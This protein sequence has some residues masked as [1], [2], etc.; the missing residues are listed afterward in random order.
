M[1]DRVKK[2]VNKVKSADKPFPPFKPA[3]YFG[4]NLLLAGLSYVML[5]A[6]KRFFVL[7]V[8]LIV[9]SFI[10]GLNFLI[11]VAS[12]FDAYFL[13]KKMKKG[14]VAVPDYNKNLVAAAIIIWVIAFISIFIV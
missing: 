13:S 10:P 12:A 6:Y 9:T 4:G 11:Y 3:A 7:I 14:E 2:S 1:A 8:L 5:R